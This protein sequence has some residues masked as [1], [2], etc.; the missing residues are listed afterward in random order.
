M[1]QHTPA[2]IVRRRM[3]NPS[4]GRAHTHERRAYLSFRRLRRPLGW[5][6]LPRGEARADFASDLTPYQRAH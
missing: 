4:A 2:N 6:D 1:W 5:I 3:T